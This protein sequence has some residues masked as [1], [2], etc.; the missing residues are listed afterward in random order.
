MWYAEHARF[1]HDAVGR[2]CYD[3]IKIGMADA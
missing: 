3:A 1:R 2:N